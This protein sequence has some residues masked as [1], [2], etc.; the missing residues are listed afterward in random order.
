MRQLSNTSEK[1][2]IQFDEFINS[3]PHL[4]EPEWLKILRGQALNSFNKDGGFPLTKNEE[5]KYTSLKPLAD[6]Y[7]DLRRSYLSSGT[8]IGLDQSGAIP[9][10]GLKSHELVFLNGQYHSGLSSVKPQLPQEAALSNVQTLLQT[11]SELLRPFLEE[12]EKSRDPLFSL[13]TAFFADG[14]YIYLPAGCIVSDPIHLIFLST[15]E[16]APNVSHLKNLII[17]EEGSSATII[18]SYMDIPLQA[19]DASP[20]PVVRKHLY[21]NNVVTQLYMGDGAN[22]EH[23]KFQ[24]EGKDSFHIATVDVTQGRNSHFISHSLA[25][26]GRLCRNNIE[27]NFA[28]EESE[29]VLNGIYFS[30]KDQLIDHH[31]TVNHSEPRC[32][33]KEFYKGI[34]DGESRGVFNGKVVVH[35]DAQGSDA[36]QENK[37]LLLSD[38]AT[39]NT[40]PQLEI[41]ADDVKCTHGA[42]IGQLD[43]DSIF[44]MR[45]R[46]ISENLARSILTRA[47]V[48]DI[49]SKIRLMPIREKIENLILSSFENRE[50]L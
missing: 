37:N 23:Y 21:F 8:A 31:T 5:W 12:S 27:V 30:N 36:Q 13:N 43:S 17:A 6:V 10:D 40:K 26:G 14:A 32:R 49:I 35:Q 9:F 1:V 29:C 2:L 42:T 7:F 22:I 33:S 38:D 19:K 46:G 3:D 25:F 18:E 4:Q 50:I 28:A 41:Y 16:S 44:Y 20:S 48:S 45:S 34:I 39:I 15:Q 11:K 47:F 24:N